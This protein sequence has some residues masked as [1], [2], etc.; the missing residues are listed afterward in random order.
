MHS[1][2]F[3]SAMLLKRKVKQKKVVVKPIEW[4][5]KPFDLRVQEGKADKWV[6]TSNSKIVT[7]VIYFL[8]FFFQGC[9]HCKTE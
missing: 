3:S 7:K 6:P 1:Y 8:F 5:E 9:V 4:I 2:F